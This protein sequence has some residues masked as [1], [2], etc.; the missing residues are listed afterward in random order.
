MKAVLFIF[1]VIPVFTSCSR[2]D[3]A[4]EFAQM[5]NTSLYLARENRFLKKELTSLKFKINELKN[6]NEFL[7]LTNENKINR[8][9]ASVIPVNP[10]NDLVEFHVYRWS[11]QQLLS[12]GR[13]AFQDGDYEKSSQYFKTLVFQFPRHQVISDEVFYKLGISSYESG[14][15]MDWAQDSFSKNCSGLPSLKLF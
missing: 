5:R 13:K 14:N 10:D 1:M 8:S 15:H 9:I 12:S 6:K 2:V 3:R 7:T 4:K 11:P